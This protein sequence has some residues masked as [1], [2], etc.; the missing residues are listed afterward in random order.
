M[1]KQWDESWT[2]CTTGRSTW[3]FFPSPDKAKILDQFNPPYQ[4]TQLLTGHCSL[5]SY[6]FRFKLSPSPNCTCGHEEEDIEHYI[7]HC[8]NHDNAKEELKILTRLSNNSWPPA[9]SVFG[10]SL[11]L[12][13]ALKRFIIQTNRLNFKS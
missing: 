3:L 11:H 4:L 12:L 9:L 5:N 6:R 7:L 10:S 8:K 2:N 13:I 1:V